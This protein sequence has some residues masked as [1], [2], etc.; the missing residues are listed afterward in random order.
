MGQ[1]RHFMFFFTL[2]PAF[3]SCKS[4]CEKAVEKTIDCAPSSGLKSQLEQTRD[5]AV[6]VCSPH[7]DEVKKCLQLS[8]CVDFHRCMKKAVVFREP[9]ARKSP[10][11]VPEESGMSTENPAQ[12]PPAEEPVR[13]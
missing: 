9:P 11:E 5:L 12:T 10:G 1:V 2:L 7:E 6:S 3:L 13:P 8:N 4:T